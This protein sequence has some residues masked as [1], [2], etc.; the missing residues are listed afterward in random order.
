MRHAKHEHA[1]HVA[2]LRTQLWRA[3]RAGDPFLVD[4]LDELLNQ[5]TSVHP[6]IAGPAIGHCGQWQAV[7]GTPMACGVCHAVL[8]A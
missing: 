6:E 5:L 2:V 8:L 7:Q 3:Q 1:K 4:I